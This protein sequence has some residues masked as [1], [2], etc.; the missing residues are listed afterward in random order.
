MWYMYFAD[1]IG[2]EDT[3]TSAINR[4][5]SFEDT[6]LIQAAEEVQSLVDMGGFVNGFNGLSDEEAKSMFMNGQSAMYMIAT[7][8]LPN[9]TT[10]EDVPQEFRDSV[11][12]FSFPLVNDKGDK[13]RF[14]GGPGVVLFVSEDS[15]VKDASKV[16][17]VYFAYQRGDRLVTEVG[18]IHASKVN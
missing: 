7:W 15:E 12:Y 8:D 3:L 17:V 1:R 9:Y 11:D 6:A 14:V 5:G 10:N 16:F 13:D 2:G 4:D 18:I